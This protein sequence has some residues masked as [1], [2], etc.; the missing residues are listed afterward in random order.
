MTLTTT[1][2][3]PLVSSL[4]SNA[5]IIVGF[6]VA[7]YAVNYVIKLVRNYSNNPDPV[8]VRAAQVLKENREIMSKMK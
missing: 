7:L 5:P 2:F 8:D 1:D 6:L 3:V 4:M